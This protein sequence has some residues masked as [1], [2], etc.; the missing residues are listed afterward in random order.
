MYLVFGKT[1][2][3]QRKLQKTAASRLLADIVLEEQ[4]PITESREAIILKFSG[5]KI[6]IKRGKE[7]FFECQPFLK[8]EDSL[9]KN[10]VAEFPRFVE[11]FSICPESYKKSC[12]IGTLHRIITQV[13][14][15][16]YL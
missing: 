15:K 5:T 14:D 13:T 7:L 8:N 12:L 2:T 16:K 4:K 1:F 10:G 3:S 11:N 9:L 6:A